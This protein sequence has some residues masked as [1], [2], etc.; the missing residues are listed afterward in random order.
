MDLL[1]NDSPELLLGEM[2]TANN[3]LF[4]LAY[5]GHGVVF[6]P[7]LDGFHIF[8]DDALLF[9][10]PHI[11]ILMCTYHHISAFPFIPPVFFSKYPTEQA[12]FSS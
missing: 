6:I 1:Q 7:G 2:F 5:L 4:L 12:L 3:V 11:Q 10:A 9:S 8:P